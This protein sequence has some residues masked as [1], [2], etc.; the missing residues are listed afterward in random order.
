MMSDENVLYI[1]YVSQ[2][3]T[4]REK[5]EGLAEEASEMAQ[6]ALKVIRADSMSAHITDKT[7]DEAWRNLA[8]EIMDVLCVLECLGYSISNADVMGCAKWRR[9]AHRLGY[10][11]GD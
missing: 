3:L 7:S 2:N 4:L 10:K 1:A 5:L 8:E 6:A 9:W 11:E